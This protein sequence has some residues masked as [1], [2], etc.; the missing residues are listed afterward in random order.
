M[1]ARYAIAFAVSRSIGPPSWRSRRIN[2]LLSWGATR[3][4]QS[5]GEIFGGAKRQATPSPRQFRPLRGARSVCPG[6]SRR[7]VSPPSWT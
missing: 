4:K 3:P 7:M 5:I 1:I 6:Q 2:G